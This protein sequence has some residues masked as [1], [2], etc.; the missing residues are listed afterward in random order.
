MTRRQLS[1]LIPRCNQPVSNAKATSNTQHC[2]ST[3]QV[4]PT[5]VVIVPESSRSCYF[6]PVGHSVSHFA[7][8]GLYAFAL[9]LNVQSAAADSGSRALYATAGLGVFPPCAVGHWRKVSSG[10]YCERGET[11]WLT[12]TTVTRRIRSTLYLTTTDFPPP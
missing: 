8:L 2:Q 12:R 3:S 7:C 5:G 10:Y 1:L 6:S 9:A 4:L 11:A